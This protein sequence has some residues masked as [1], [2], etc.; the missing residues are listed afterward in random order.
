M[1]LSHD[2]VERLLRLLETS[3]FDELHL[4]TDDIK[5][6]LRRRGSAPSAT[7]ALSAA[8]APQASAAAGTSRTASSALPVDPSLVEIRAAMLGTF[9]CAPKPGAEPFIR[10]G[11]RVEPDTTVGVIEVMKLMNSMHAGKAGVVAEILVCDGDLVEFDQV[12]LRLRPA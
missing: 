5:I 2:D 6:N 7:D 3:Q 1:S 4:E 11:D 10:V 12:L 8:Q 9:Y